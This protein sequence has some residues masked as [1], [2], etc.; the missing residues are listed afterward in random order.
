MKKFEGCGHEAS[1]SLEG[2]PVWTGERMIP[3]LAPRSVYWEHFYRYRFA[4]NYV[5][6]KRVLDIASG[7]GYG[8]SALMKAGASSVVGI[9]ISEE[10]VAHAKKKYNLNYIVAN[11]EAIPVSDESIEVIV[12]FETIEHLKNPTIFLKECARIL[13]PKGKLVISTPNRF[14]PNNYSR[15]FHLM[16]YSE[17]DFMVLLHKYFSQIKMYYQIPATAPSWSLWGIIIQMNIWFN[18]T[19]VFMFKEILHSIIEFNAHQKVDN[20]KQGHKI[21]DHTPNNIIKRNTLL[22]RL[23]NPLVVREKSLNPKGQAKYFVAIA[24]KF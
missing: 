5:F 14:R 3:E 10:T 1:S 21:E 19:R 17:G 12:C 4:C 20:K 24:E 13:A 16:E 8:T 7:E 2:S 23:I 15:E 6:N 22:S 9:D 11:A 18:K